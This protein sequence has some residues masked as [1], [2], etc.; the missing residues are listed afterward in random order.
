M[1]KSISQCF[2]NLD[3]DKNVYRRSEYVKGRVTLNVEEN[4]QIKAVRVYLYGE[5]LTK[6]DIFL[7][8]SN[9]ENIGREKYVGHYV[10]FHNY[11]QYA[12]FYIFFSAGTNN[13]PVTLVKGKQ[14]YRFTFKL[15]DR[16]LPS[17]F[18]GEYGAVRYWLKVLVDRPMF[19]LNRSWYRAFTV[20]HNIDINTT[21]LKVLRT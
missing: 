10:T 4:I 18:E 20:L 7:D 3:G 13:P 8:R 12:F 21:A 19:N 17:S 16:V 15:P 5:A 11:Q 14:T 9:R 2:V 6:W 1:V